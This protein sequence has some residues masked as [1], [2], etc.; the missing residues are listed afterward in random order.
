[1]S[2]FVSWM[3]LDDTSTFLDVFYCSLN[4]FKRPLLP[5]G[6]VAASLAKPPSTVTVDSS[7]RLTVFFIFMYCWCEC[8]WARM[9]Y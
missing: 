8:D 4:A 2:D 9:R 7:K 5:L 6:C 1:M 3:F